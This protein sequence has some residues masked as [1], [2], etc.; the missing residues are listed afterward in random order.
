MDPIVLK[1]IP[2]CNPTP[3]TRT[4]PNIDVKMPF[5]GKRPLN[6]KK[7]QNFAAKR[8]MR[9]M[10]HVFLPSFVEIGKAEVTEPVRDIPDEKL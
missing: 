9:T 7:V 8:F 3:V 4:P 2:S 6:G 5:W 10:V 1:S